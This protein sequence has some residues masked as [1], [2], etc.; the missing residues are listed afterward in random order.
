MNNTGERIKQEGKFESGNAVRDTIINDQTGRMLKLYQEREKNRKALDAAKK[1]IENETEHKR[2]FATIDTKFGGSAADLF[3]EEFR[4]STVGLVS[5]EEFRDKRRK[6]DD[7]IKA[8]NQEPEEPKRKVIQKKCNAKLSFD[9]DEEEEEEAVEVPRTMGFLGKNPTV[10]T[11]FLPDEGRRVAI[12][13][14]KE[15]LIAEW[16]ATQ[17]KE[18]KKIIQVQFSYWDGAGHR[19]SIDIEKGTT[20]KDFLTGAFK[21]LEADFPDLRG[22]SQNGL[23]YIKEDLIIPGNLTFYDLIKSRAQGPHGYLFDYEFDHDGKIVDESECPGG[24]ER[25]AGKVV[26]RRWYERNK[27]VFPAS[28][29]GHFDINKK[30]ETDVEKGKMSYGIVDEETQ[31]AENSNIKL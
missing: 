24:S 10:D 27:H 3:E 30:Y 26:D 7:L 14:K 15:E 1:E 13:K 4:R 29:W 28:R 2:K 21:I 31:K 22:R 20:V 19:R 17:K 23:L 8:A 25:H 6:V 18:K 16:S 5:I 11:S 9:E 12:E